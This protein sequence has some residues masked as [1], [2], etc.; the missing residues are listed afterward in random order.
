MDRSVAPE[1]RGPAEVDL[2]HAVRAASVLDESLNR[3]HLLSILGAGPPVGIEDSDHQSDASSMA[4]VALLL[5]EQRAMQEKY[6][7][8]LAVRNEGNAGSGETSSLRAKEARSKENEE[9]R[10]VSEKL[11]SITK[12]LCRSLKET[13]N[14]LENWKK[15]AR[16]RADLHSSLS[17]CLREFHTGIASAYPSIS[18]AMSPHMGDGSG[19]GFPSPHLGAGKTILAQSPQHAALLA[20][21]QQQM[22]PEKMDPQPVSFSS[23]AKRVMEEVEKKRWAREIVVR[24]KDAQ[25][26]LRNLRERVA[27]DQ[28]AYADDSKKREE[29]YKSLKE[30]IHDLILE[31][32]TSNE[33]FRQESKGETD[34]LSL[35]QA[36][37]LREL[38]RKLDKLEVEIVVEK[39]AN[40]KFSSFLEEKNTE[41]SLLLDKWAGKHDQETLEMDQELDRR[42]HERASLL[43]KI[44]ELEDQL[45]EKRREFELQKKYSENWFLG[46]GKLFDL[47]KRDAAMKLLMLYRAFKI[48][49]KKKKKGGKKKKKKK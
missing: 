33:K 46:V 17:A 34:A 23:F 25:K 21:Q 8:L 42:T 43:E 32:R 45:A 7:Q 3:L 9:I 44:Q 18:F 31:I 27:E 40:E 14:D 12:K 10:I 41:L 4:P 22:I 11:K 24:E 36:E 26:E 28:K 29:E 48:R 1:V 15:V 38:K 13:P 6:E 49:Q 30:K 20:Q 16:E 19:R 2:I 5:E 47:Y 39:T 37:R 35:S